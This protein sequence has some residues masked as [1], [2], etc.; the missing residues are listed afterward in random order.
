MKI[1]K[2][3][4]RIGDDRPMKIVYI[5]HSNRSAICEYEGQQNTDKPGIRRSSFPL[6]E[7]IECLQNS[8]K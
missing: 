6:N 3:A 7:L 1:G 4:S 5:Y 2:I 8:N